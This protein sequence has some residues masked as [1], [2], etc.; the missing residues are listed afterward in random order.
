MQSLCSL[1]KITAT[2]RINAFIAEHILE[3]EG[4][5]HAPIYVPGKNMYDPNIMKQMELE[6]AE[7]PA[8]QFE[9]TKR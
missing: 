8:K 5:K 3:N 4:T 1:T 2:R 9:D 7:E 6:D